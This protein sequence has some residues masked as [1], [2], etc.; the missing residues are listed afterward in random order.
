MRINDLVM[1]GKQQ[2]L[3]HDPCMHESQLNNEFTEK[4]R[5][6]ENETDGA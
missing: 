5:K 3:V 6:K 4:K 2:S 1:A